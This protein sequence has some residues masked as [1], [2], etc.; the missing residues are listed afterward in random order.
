MIKLLTATVAILIAVVIGLGYV[1]FFYE[2][3]KEVHD[4]A[5]TQDL[6]ENMVHQLMYDHIYGL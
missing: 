2:E 6:N 4:K 3:G 5:H 1:A